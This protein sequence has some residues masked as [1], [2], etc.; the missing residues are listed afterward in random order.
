MNI[1]FKH[2]VVLMYLFC[3]HMNI[4]VRNAFEME[5]YEYKIK[6]LHDDSYV[7]FHAPQV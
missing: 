3:M 4:S 5:I 7:F 6:A 1:I 2:P